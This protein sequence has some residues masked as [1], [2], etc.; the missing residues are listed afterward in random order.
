MKIDFV[1]NRKYYFTFSLILVAVCILS[2]VFF[3]AELDIQFKG[4]SIVT[5][6]HTGEV[7]LAQVQKA[8][9]EITGLQVNVQEGS[10]AVTGAQSFTV[11]LAGS[12][13]IAPETQ[14]EITSKLNELFPESQVETTA[15]SNV[16]ASIGRDFFLK[17]MVAMIFAAAM[18]IVYIGIRF[19]KI[20]GWSA[21]VMGV[22]AL[23]HDVM[24][25]FM[26]F[27]LFRIPLNDNFIAV[28]LTILGCS[29]NDTIVIYDRIRENK[30]LSSNG[31]ASLAEIVNLSINQSLGRAVN[32]TLTI[33]LAMM[34]VAAMGYVYQIDTIIT[35]A[36]PMVVGMIS[37]CYSSLCL[38]GPLWVMWENRQAGK[39]A[40]K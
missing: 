19:R 21:G 5:Y 32:T 28:V 4:G 12:Q 2:L 39:R 9:G 36:F 1:G 37:G 26:V 17:S 35:F 25:A 34:V 16:D 6:S 29:I 30:R 33:V 3:G 20:G 22:V 11:S 24:V 38:S 14:I 18:I 23:L 10:D 31:R 27:V 13:G 40:A 8:V 7:D 15:I